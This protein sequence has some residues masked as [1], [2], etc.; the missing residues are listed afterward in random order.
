MIFSET[1]LKGAYI[2][3]AT[4][5]KDNRGFF[6]RTWCKREL[7]QHGLDTNIVQCNISYN[8]KK[9][10]LRG[11][12]YQKNPYSEVKYVRCIKGALYDVIV[13]LREDSK[14]FG[15]WIG[16]ELTEENKRALYIPKGFAHGFETLLDNTYLYYQVTEYYTPEAEGGIRWNDPKFNIIW[17]IDNPVVMS[18]KDNSW[19]LFLGGRKNEGKII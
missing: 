1:K 16:V 19:P 13:D 18:S 10:T 7:E 17:P 8:L 12:H 14:T 2:I 5:I 3:E 6:S 15:Q 11:M 9:G 4:P